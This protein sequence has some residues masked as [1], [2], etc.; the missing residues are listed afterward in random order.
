MSVSTQYTG[1]SK[2]VLILSAVKDGACYLRNSVILGNGYGGH[3][4][5]HA[6]KY[7]KW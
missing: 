5:M 6:E 2:I 7:K 3:S 4:V 1:I